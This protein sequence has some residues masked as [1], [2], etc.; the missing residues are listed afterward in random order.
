MTKI[1]RTKPHSMDLNTYIHL[2]EG[3][4][5]ITLQIHEYGGLACYI[6]INMGSRVYCEF[7]KYGL[8]SIKEAKL[9]IRQ[10]Y[11]NFSHLYQSSKKE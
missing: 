3:N 11:S 8:N 5:K 2:E 4:I 1:S 6:E 9:F 7:K 10:I